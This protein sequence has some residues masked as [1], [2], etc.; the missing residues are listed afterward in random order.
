MKWEKKHTLEETVEWTGLPESEMEP[1][2][3]YVNGKTPGICGTYAAAALTVLM[4]KREEVVTQTMDELLKGMEASIEYAFPYR[5]TFY[6]DVQRGLNH[7]WKKYGYK[8]HFNLFSEKVVPAL[9]EDGVP[10]VVGTTAALGSPYKNH[11]VVVYQYAFDSTGK[12]WYKA[13]DNHGSTTT[14]IPAV[15]TL[16]AVWL[17][18]L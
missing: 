17:E 12:L 5:G 18:K 8:T 2:K 4:A 6:W 15:Q 11:W 14:V 16:C 9:I 7:E 13:Y 10:V 3:A 1:F